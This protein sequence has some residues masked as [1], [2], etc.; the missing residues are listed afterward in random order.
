[1]AVVSPMGLIPP[2]SNDS[3]IGMYL[4]W[5]TLLEL[6]LCYDILATK[7]LAYPFVIQQVTISLSLFYMGKHLC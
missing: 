1:M 4:V 6:K 3:F 5:L 2:D 7:T